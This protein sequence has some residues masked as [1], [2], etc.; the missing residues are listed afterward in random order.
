MNPL[1]ALNAA[2][3]QTAAWRACADA[4]AAQLGGLTAVAYISDVR[5]FVA[6]AGCPPW[7]INATH[8]RTWASELRDSHSPA[9]TNRKMAALASLYRAAA[10]AGLWTGPNPF[11]QPGLRCR[12]ALFGRASYPT[13]DEVRRVLAAIPLDDAQGW[14]DLGLFYGLW[15]CARRISEWLNLKWGD[16]QAGQNGGVYFTYR[17][18]GGRPL[19]QVIP[20]DVFAVIN[21]Y[22]DEAHREV[23][24]RDDYVFIGL[25]GDG[26]S[27]LSV[28]YAG[29]LLCHYGTLAGIEERK[30]HLHGL[31]HAGARYRRDHGATSL[32]LQNL[33]GHKHLT[34][35]EIYVAGVLDEPQDRLAWTI[36]A[37]LP[38]A[39]RRRL[40]N[41][42]IMQPV[43]PHQ[44]TTT[45]V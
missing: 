6:W 28:P 34:T 5:Q 2:D 9:S 36:G 7:Q 21:R 40:Y 12:V 4:W 14:R 29:R 45:E 20:E 37:V 42:R 18:K 19:R 39:A 16:I 27:P 13:T 41:Q 24:A 38:P 15:G 44:Q 3:P 32:E 11:E 10:T 33:L 22:L 23:L 43:S 25:H 8:A 17:S 1:D 30:L 26:G 35:T 31:R